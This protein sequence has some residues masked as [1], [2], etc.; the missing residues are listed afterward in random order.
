MKGI[1]KIS[2]NKNT[3]KNNKSRGYLI[4]VNEYDITKNIMECWTKYKN[5]EYTKEEMN[6]CIPTLYHFRD[7]MK[8]GNVF[9]YSTCVIENAG[10]NFN[11]FKIITENEAKQ[12]LRIKKLKRL[13]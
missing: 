9:E 2:I 6:D 13:L 5:G 11:D 10:W 12:F 3:I 1:P 8:V 7:F 4:R